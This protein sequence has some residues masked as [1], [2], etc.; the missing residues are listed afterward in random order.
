MS[1]NVQLPGKNDV[2]GIWPAFW[3]MGN[4]GRAGYGATLDGMWPYTYDACDVGTLQNQTMGDYPDLAY[5]SGIE[6]KALSF[7]PGQ[8]LSRCTC[9]NEIHPGPMHDDGTFVGRSAAEIDVFEA[10]IDPDIDQSLVSMSGQ[11][12]PFNPHYDW[13]NDTEAWL[14]YPE[15]DRYNEFQGG[16]WQQSTSIRLVTDPSVYEKSGGNY[17]TY[18][19]EYNP[20]YGHEG[21]IAWHIADENRYTVFADAM[22]AVPEL[23]IADRF[24][25]GE[26]MYMI[27]N[28]GISNNFGGIDWDGLRGTFPNVMSIDWVRVYQRRDRINVGCDPPSMPTAAYIDYYRDAYTNPNLTTWESLGENS[29]KN[30]ILHQDDPDCSDARKLIPEE[31]IGHHNIKPVLPATLRPPI[32]APEQPG[33]YIMPPPVPVPDFADLEESQRPK[34]FPYFEN[35]PPIWRPVHNLGPPAPPSLENAPPFDRPAPNADE[36]AEAEAEAEKLA[37][38]EAELESTAEDLANTINDADTN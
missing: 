16:E 17:S 6:G 8:R 30:A 9:A 7:L 25:T 26:P 35:P 24:V 13:R 22:R 3:I 31:L 10:L 21:Y 33:P 34:V 36:V 15:Q 12:A 20:G 19:L 23:G 29:I 5:T 11:F 1:A 2:W 4:L 37:M 27:L 14:K 38:K 18:G 28:N 32:P